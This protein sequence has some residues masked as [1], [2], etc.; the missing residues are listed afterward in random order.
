MSPTAVN[1][2]GDARDTS[3]KISVVI[4]TYNR[5]DKLPKC[6]ESFCQVDYNGDWELI[7][8]NNNSTDT[9]ADYL[10]SL[11]KTTE[12]PL[13]VVFEKQKG[14]ASARN[15]G[16]K[17]ARFEYI[18]FTDDD[19]YPAPDYLNEIRSAVLRYNNPAIGFMGGR[20]DLHNPLDFPVTIQTSEEIE[21]F[22]ATNIIKPGRIHGANF[23]FTKTALESIHYFD[24]LFGSGSMFPA[25]D[26]DAMASC[27]EHG[28]EGVYDPRIRVAHDH[29]RRKEEE[30]VKL[31]ADYD[32]GRGAFLCKHIIYCSGL[33][34]QYFLFWLKR[35]RWISR[36]SF[37]NEFRAARGYSKA[38]K[39][40]R[41]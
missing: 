17:A 31:H 2:T 10:Q 8:V 36:D 34:L 7:V 12:L 40:H 39:H 37:V 38:R 5:I 18:A 24:P 6:I 21:H 15:C 3:P 25:E 22:S 19:C 32:L 4:C 26:I 35:L 23:I 13:R 33:R 28:F 16:A 20:V 41:H 30:L 9:T 14:L 29:G 11:E 27:I 1:K